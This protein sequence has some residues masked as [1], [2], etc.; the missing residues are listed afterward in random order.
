MDE[1]MNGRY[2]NILTINLNKDNEVLA[3]SEKWLVSTEQIREAHS[4]ANYNSIASIHEAL[5]QLGYI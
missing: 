2:K 1:L 4:I 3:W 5:V